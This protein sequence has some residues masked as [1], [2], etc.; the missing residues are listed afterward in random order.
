MSQVREIISIN[1]GQAG[2]QLGHVLWQQ[3]NAEHAVTPGEEWDPKKQLENTVKV[4]MEEK[5]DEGKEEQPAP[6]SIEDI[7]FG[8]EDAANNFAR[9]HYTVGKELMDIVN[10]RV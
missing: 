4:Q 8:K 2:C 3:Y 7:T 10:E 6:Q 9:G 5:K 1:V